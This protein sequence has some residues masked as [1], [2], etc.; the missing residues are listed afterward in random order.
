MANVGY[1]NCAAVILPA[2]LGYPM[3][4]DLKIS[5]ADLKG[6][7][8]PARDALKKAVA[9]YATDLIEEANRIE[10]GRGS[11][12]PEVTRAM[13]DDA[14]FALRR[15][16]GTPPRNLVLKIL[17]IGAAVL[18]LLVGILFDPAK[19][20]NGGYMTFFIVVVAG[21]ILAVTLSI[22]RE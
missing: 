16:L 7:S 21:A 20:Q 14:A 8:Q 6:F 2:I 3:P 19:L 5:E 4:V 15:G 18:S 9:A 12:E 13:V 10:A 22:L 11:P 17:R 1:R